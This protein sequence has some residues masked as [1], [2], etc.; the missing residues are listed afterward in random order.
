MGRE[1][2][3]PLSLGVL[4]CFIPV[5]LKLTHDFPGSS[6]CR[7]SPSEILPMLS[8]WSSAAR[9]V[10]H[11]ATDQLAHLIQ[12]RVNSPTP[13]STRPFLI[14]LAS[15]GS[16]HVEL[17]FML[18]KRKAFILIFFC[19]PGTS[20]SLKHLHSGWMTSTFTAFARSSESLF[21]NIP[22]TPS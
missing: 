13:T 6:V 11:I 21:L 2:D 19:A 3:C 22:S 14:Y 12:E 17:P 8:Q 9:A 10:L 7:I 15:L 16:T 1:S 20:S 4:E 18:N 5:L